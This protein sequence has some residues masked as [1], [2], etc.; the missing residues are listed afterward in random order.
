MRYMGSKRRIADAILPIILKGRKAKQYFVEPFCGGCNITV[1]V[2]GKRIA[3]DIHPELIEMYKALQGGWKP[4]KKIT[5]SEYNFIRKSPYVDPALRAYAG[6]THSFGGVYFGTYRRNPTEQASGNLLK[7]NYSNVEAVGKQAYD[8]VVSMVPKLKGVTFVCGNY[9]ELVIPPNSIVYCDP[10]YQGTS[11]Y[12]A[13]RFP[14]AN[15]FNWLRTLKE[16]GHTV[17]VSE[18]KAPEDF[19]CVWQQEVYN[20]LNSMSEKRKAVTEKLFML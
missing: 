1:R 5:E 17:F 15:F 10:P 9:Y 12:K 14:S 8:M 19:K 7:E 4:P 6:F 11:E 18:Y 16:A 13:N 20:G 2:E 3:N